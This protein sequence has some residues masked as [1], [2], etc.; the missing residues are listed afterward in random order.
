MISGHA[1][2]CIIAFFQFGYGLS[3]F[4][5]FNGNNIWEMTFIKLLKT[6]WAVLLLKSFRFGGGAAGLFLLP[7]LRV[8]S[9]LCPSLCRREVRR[10]LVFCC[11]GTVSAWEF[12][13]A[14]G[15]LAEQH[16]TDHD[17]AG[18]STNQLPNMSRRAPRGEYIE[19]VRL[20]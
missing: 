19:T 10:V 6:T 18:S 14:T 11:A 3:Y 15:E 13:R 1:L 4:Y 16:I 12:S 7:A 9:R 2:I 20:P 8:R 5:T 17:Q